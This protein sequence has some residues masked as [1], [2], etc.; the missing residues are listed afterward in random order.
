MK[1]KFVLKYINSWTSK[2]N[3]CIEFTVV[4]FIS[5]YWRR[6][7]RIDLGWNY[8]WKS[9]C[10]TTLSFT[11]NQFIFKT[12]FNHSKAVDII[13][14]KFKA[15]FNRDENVTAISNP[16][17]DTVDLVVQ[18]SGCY[19]PPTLT[20]KVAAGVALVLFLFFLKK[21]IF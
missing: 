5:R 21:M 13:V 17:F 10:K 14:A 11:I 9:T 16:K 2:C 19:K 3:W 1:Y 7:F 15:P 20:T 18:G 12:F 8:S 4:S 6:Q